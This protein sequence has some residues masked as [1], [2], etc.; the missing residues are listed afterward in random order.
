[1]LFLADAIYM[2]TLHSLER[3]YSLGILYMDNITGDKLLIQIH[4]G[5]M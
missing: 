2:R 5:T 1:M 4:Y 3:D